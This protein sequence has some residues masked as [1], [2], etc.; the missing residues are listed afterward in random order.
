MMTRAKRRTSAAALPRGSLS[1]QEEEAK[2]RIPL[3][4]RNRVEA[5]AAELTGYTF[6]VRG[7]VPN[8]DTYLDD[9]AYSLL[10]QGYALRLRHLGDHAEVGLKR[11]AEGKT[12]T[13]QRRE[14]LAAAVTLDAAQS[15]DQW[16]TAVTE[17]IDRLGADLDALRPLVVVRQQRHKAVVCRGESTLLLAE[18]SLDQVHFSPPDDLDTIWQAID[19]LEIERLTSGPPPD[20]TALVDEVQ[21]T[22]GLKSVTASKFERALAARVAAQ[23]DGHAAVTTEMELAEAARLLLHQQF[24]AILQAEHGVRAGKE[25]EYVHSMRVAI[26][27]GRAVLRL[28][29]HCFRGRVV[30]ALR[31][32]LKQLGRLL[33]PVRDAD[34][35]LANLRDFRR[36]LDRDH[37]QAIKPLRRDLRNQRAAAF[38]RLSSHLNG[39]EHRALITDLDTF[40][41]TPGSA[42]AK[43][44]AAPETRPPRQVRHTVPSIIWAEFEQ[45][46][47]YEVAFAGP[48][49]PSLEVYHALRI[50]AKYLRYSLEFMRDILG[51]P[52]EALITQLKE[53]QDQLGLLNDAHVEQGRLADWQKQMDD[54]PALARRAAEVDATIAM[55]RAGFPTHLAHFISPQNRLLLGEALA[56]L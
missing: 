29:G 15:P 36:T 18:W 52:G 13:I 26:R 51:A 6:E 42:L 25:P 19:E 8:T 46:R 24:L 37:Q 47:A 28:F 39:E 33:G 5:A 23:H 50:Q 41:S 14:E 48:E 32:Q 7:Q 27:R 55:L 4:K 9:P 31:R 49:L 17:V 20:F 16:P 38:K 44:K 34:V 2:F 22:F 3:D 10:R 43:S 35:A 11:L 56:R 21:Q 30:R 12:G 45:V 53:F 40:C 54:N 1:H